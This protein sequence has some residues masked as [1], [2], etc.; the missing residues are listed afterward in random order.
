MRA[1]PL[2]LGV[3][4]AACGGSDREGIAVTEA[5]PVERVAPRPPPRVAPLDTVYA[6][7]GQ[8]ADPRLDT[9]LA[10][11]AAADTLEAVS[12]P[13]F[14][15]FWPRFREALRTGPE[16][17]A[18]LADLAPESVPLDPLLDDAVFRDRVLA[19]TAR[20][21][22][23][24]GTVRDV[25]VRVG[26]DRDGNVV[27]EDEAETESGLGL[28]FEVVDGAYRLVRLEVGG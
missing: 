24:A 2:V 26:F 21:F 4:L 14:R 17:V 3:L 5:A 6:D 23:R 27:P 13:D 25:W 16:A 8:Y 18:A 12:A 19:L 22:R 7:S 1:A 20:D 28:R 10:D 9:L 15:A 11:S